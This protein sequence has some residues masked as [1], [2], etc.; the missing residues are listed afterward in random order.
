MFDAYPSQVYTDTVAKKIEARSQKQ[1]YKL[2]APVN[3]ICYICARTKPL[4][5]VNGLLT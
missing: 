4:F 2:Y 5:F 1:C 3:V